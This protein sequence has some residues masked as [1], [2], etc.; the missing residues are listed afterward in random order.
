MMLKTGEMEIF[1]C[2]ENS[3]LQT[4]LALVLCNVSIHIHT[5]AVT[6]P[7]LRVVSPLIAQFTTQSDLTPQ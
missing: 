3:I 2:F 7:L 1:L 5:S 4:V 6:D